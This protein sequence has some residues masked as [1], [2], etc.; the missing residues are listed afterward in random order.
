MIHRYQ[1]FCRDRNRMSLSIILQSN[2]FVFMRHEILITLRNLFFF[3]EQIKS[4][5]IQVWNHT[6]VLIGK[7]NLKANPWEKCGFVC[8]YFDLVLI[9]MQRSS[10]RK[11]STYFRTDLISTLTSLEM[12]NFTHFYW[13]LFVEDEMKVRETSICNDRQSIVVLGGRGDDIE[14][15][16]RER[17]RKNTRLRTALAFFLS[18]SYAGAHPLSS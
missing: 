3:W 1:K 14:K 4:I 7:K 5:N 13:F 2:F 17:E 10:Y 16:E 18:L 9:R 6:H 8:V 12:N 15:W 11:L